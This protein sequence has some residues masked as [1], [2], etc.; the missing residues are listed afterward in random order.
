MEEKYGDCTFYADAVSGNIASR[1][2]LEHF[3][4]DCV[5]HEADAFQRDELIRDIYHY[6]L[7]K[8]S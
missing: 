2:I 8:Y 4:F 6:K 7:Q 3:G 1:K 5:S